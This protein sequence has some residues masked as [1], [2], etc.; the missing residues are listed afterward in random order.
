VTFDA[1][2]IDD[3]NQPQI[4]KGDKGSSVLRAQIL[5]DRAHFS[6]GEL[7]GDF[8]DNL[9]K[10]VAAY[11]A[12]Q[13]LP[14]NGVVDEATW[15]LLNGD[16]ASLLLQYTITPED[17]QGPWVKVP[18]D[19][20]AQA[21]LPYLGYGSPLEELSEKFHSSPAVMK[22]LNP[23][24]DF[25]KA[26]QTL[27]VPNVLTMPPGEAHKVVVSRSESSVRA[28]D[29]MGKLIAFYICTSGSD[30][31]PLPIGDWKIR[32]IKKNPE[33]HYNAQLFWDAKNKDDRATIKPGPNN[34]VGLVWMDLSKEHYGIHGTPEPSKIG[35]TFSHGCIRLTNWDALELASMV[36]PGTPALLRE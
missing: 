13:H 16:T 20:M 31:D 7:D 35:H 19:M 32:Y 14:S 23:G 6:C 24:A 17:E 21:A 12:E 36:K 26:G 1:S 15:Q 34:P 9:Q 25:S 8:G 4:S 10:T 28:Y 33:F 18:A 11:Q 30:H 22:A 5:L 2:V 3:P 29:D 27:I